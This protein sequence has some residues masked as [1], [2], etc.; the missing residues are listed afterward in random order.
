[1]DFG[2]LPPEVNSWRMYSGPGCG[3]MLAAAAAWDQ[4]AGELRS[5]AV[6]YGSVIS[7]LTSGPWQGASA[8][9]MTAAAAPFVAWLAAAAGQAEEAAAG[10]KAAAAAFEAAYAMTVPPPL[11][12]A[13][14]AQLMSLIA[15][16][17]VGQNS[18]AIAA[19]EAHYDEMWAQDA[20]AM[21]GYAGSAAVASK[22]S[23]FTSPPITVNPAGLASQG[24]ALAQTASTSSATETQTALTRLT[25]AVPQALQ[26]LTSPG[27]ST[28]STSLMSAVN[29]LNSLSTPVRTAA[30]LANTPITSVNSL[31]S[32][33]KSLGSTTTT[34]AS[35]VKAGESAFAGGLS[36]LLGA[37]GSP[38]S[39]GS[40]GP[41]VSAGIGQ[42][43][44]IG[45]LSVPQAWTAAPPAGGVGERTARDADRVDGR[46]RFE[47]SPVAICRAADCDS[48]FT[49]GRVTAPLLASSWWHPVSAG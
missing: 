32:I 25:S 24:A 30:Y 13:N 28:S 9:S 21:Y 2:M 4:V 16:N 31:N 29:S 18:P 11:I 5:A 40:G 15:T 42:A 34:A 14:R 12:A 26:S 46:T 7:G 45:P 1:M 6:D 10:A 48:P 44:S 35:S 22:V 37:V 3:P 41:A 39:P 19:I 36:S 38:A 43:I 49:V 33:A 17:V 47:R 20:A 23:A 8:S 27:S